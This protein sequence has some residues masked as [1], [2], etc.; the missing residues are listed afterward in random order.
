MNP[1]GD[2]ANAG[3]YLAGVGT[4]AVSAAGIEVHGSTGLCS[5]VVGILFIQFAL[6]KQLLLRPSVDEKVFRK[7]QS[8]SL[9]GF[10][11]A[12]SYPLLLIRRQAAQNVRQ[13]PQ[14]HLMYSM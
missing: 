14:Q 3:G 6:Q 10:L 11:S 5:W 9:Q 1:I 13:K 8:N 12:A 4:D 2:A 7:V